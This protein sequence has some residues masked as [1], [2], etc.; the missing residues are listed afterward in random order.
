M[1]GFL[2]IGYTFAGNIKTHRHR[3][4]GLCLRNVGL[5]S[6]KNIEI[7]CLVLGKQCRSRK[8]NHPDKTDIYNGQNSVLDTFVS[9]PQMSEHTVPDYENFSVCIY[10][11]IYTF[12]SISIVLSIVLYIY[13][14]IYSPIYISIYPAIYSHLPLFFYVYLSC[15]P[16]NRALSQT[17]LQHQVRLTEIHKTAILKGYSL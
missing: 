1:V 12:L 2:A 16:H 5:Q 6:R 10:I 13:R 3:L 7:L 4:V 11:Y 9:D 15:F 8:L 14:P 17:F